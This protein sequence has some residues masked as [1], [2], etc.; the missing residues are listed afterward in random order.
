MRTWIIWKQLIGTIERFKTKPE[1]FT[2]GKYKKP[3]VRVRNLRFQT[4]NKC[5]KGNKFFW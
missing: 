2:T 5:A 1:R 3:L 4:E